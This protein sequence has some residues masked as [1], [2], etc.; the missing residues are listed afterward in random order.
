[1]ESNLVVNPLRIS[2][3][4]PVLNEES[5][6]G[7][8]LRSIEKLD[9][10][11]RDME[12]LIVDNGSKDRT[13]DIVRQNHCR[14][15]VEPKQS[16]YAARN[17]GII[18][19]DGE[20]IAFTDGDCLVSRSWLRTLLEGFDRREIGAVAGPVLPCDPAT[21]TQKFQARWSTPAHRPDNLPTPFAVT[22]NVAYKREV[23]ERVGLFDERWKSGGDIDLA[24]RMQKNGGFS[25]RF[26]T[27][28]GVVYHQNNENF[29]YL[30]ASAAKRGYGWRVL[31]S[32]YTDEFPRHDNRFHNF[33]LNQMRNAQVPSRRLH[34]YQRPSD[35][36]DSLVLELMRTLWRL[37]WSV[38]FLGAITPSNSG[39]KELSL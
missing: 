19:S 7:D 36:L 31:V 6:V 16:S 37:A 34:R 3:V 26:L 22:A 1:M 24:W 5:T 38:G 33:S 35:L 4:V 13:R 21:L 15:L 28:A 18:N 11:R 27:K 23:F 8:L 9:Y 12:V 25:L 2:V 20:V 14:L 39:T 29:F 30:M 32:K 17:L 10:P